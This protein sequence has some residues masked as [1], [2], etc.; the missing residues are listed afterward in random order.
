MYKY[1]GMQLV[2]VLKRLPRLVPNPDY[3]S[4]S[5]FSRFLRFLGGHA[6]DA[7]IIILQM[8]TGHWPFPIITK[9]ICIC[10]YAYAYA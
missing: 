3:C 6:N 9:Q 8:A 10:A 1:P 2:L 5:P 4:Q 7:I